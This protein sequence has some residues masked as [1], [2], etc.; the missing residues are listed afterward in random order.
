M[1][2]CSL[3]TSKSSP[4]PSTSTNSAT[5]QS[6][7]STYPLATTLTHMHST[8]TSPVQT[9]QSTSTATV[10]SSTPDQPNSDLETPSSGM[11]P[12]ALPSVATSVAAAV[13]TLLSLDSIK[14]LDSIPFSKAVNATTTSISRQVTS[15]ASIV[16]AP[17]HS[18]LALIVGI[19]SGVLGLVMLIALGLYM[20]WRSHGLQLNQR[21]TAGEILS[22][23]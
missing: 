23:V 15:P 17:T 12:S 5:D 6:S 13:T 9:S 20:R 11:Y 1:P 22:Y 21:C 14:P 8:L 2:G 18:R 16:A 10:A 19:L 3:T 4:P 7:H